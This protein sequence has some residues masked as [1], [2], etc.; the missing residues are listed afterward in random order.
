MFKAEQCKEL[1]ILTVNKTGNR[2]MKQENNSNVYI[3]LCVLFVCLCVCVCRL[4]AAILCGQHRGMER[5]FHQFHWA[6]LQTGQPALRYLVQSEAGC[7]EQRR[8]GTHQWDH[9]GKDPRE[10]WDAW[11]GGWRK[12]VWH[13][14]HQK[15]TLDTYFPKRKMDVHFCRTE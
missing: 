14:K 8:S 10:R 4:C 11:N 9:R 1:L 15:K 6:L 2:V 12:C 13:S 3:I 5:R 7:K